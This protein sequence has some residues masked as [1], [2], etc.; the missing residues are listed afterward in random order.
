MNIFVAL[1]F[2]I[3]LFTSPTTCADV[4]EKNQSSFAQQ[5][6]Q[7]ALHAQ[8]SLASDHSSVP[9]S[10]SDSLEFHH[11]CCSMHCSTMY[12]QKGVSVVKAELLCAV[13]NLQLGQFVPTGLTSQLSRPPKA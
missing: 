6:A 10:G 2:A 7:T 3:Y 11:H 8:P 1:T 12:L 5:C 9:M 4:H 13:E